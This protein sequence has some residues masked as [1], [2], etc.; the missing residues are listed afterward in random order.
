MHLLKGPDLG[1]SMICYDGQLEKKRQKKK[2]KPT[3]RWDLNPLLMIM[4]WALDRC[5]TNSSQFFRMVAPNNWTCL[6]STALK[7]PWSNTSQYLNLKNT[8][9]KFE[10]TEAEAKPTEDELRVVLQVVLQRR[11]RL[12]QIRVSNHPFVIDAKVK[13]IFWKTAA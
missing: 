12:Q 13:K 10:S 5:A 9:E 3:A 4:G 7:V 2:K 1:H 11:P 6:D 8:R